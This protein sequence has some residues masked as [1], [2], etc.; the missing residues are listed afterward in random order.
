MRSGFERAVDLIQ[1]Y[2]WTRST[3]YRRASAP[4]FFA[5]IS[6][7]GP[8]WRLACIEADENSGQRVRACPALNVRIWI[9]EVCKVCILSGVEATLTDLRRKT[10][11]VVRPAMHGGK[12]V[13]ITE[14]G[15]PT[16]KIV[17]VAKSADRKA[18]L[19]LLRQI[20]PLEL[21]PRK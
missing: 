9:A 16:F 1:L 5:P 13:T 7:D 3:F 10:T 4:G 18:A 11:K 12:E 17:P 2:G 8:M 21:P 20:G 15:E 19:E 6:V 14:R